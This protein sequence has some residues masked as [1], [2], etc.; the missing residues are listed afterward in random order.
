MKNLPS[1]A[2][3]KI[4]S[5]VL[6]FKSVFLTSICI[7]VIPC[8]VPATLKSISPLKSSKPIISDKI[9][10]FSPSLTK[11]MAIP[12][13]G[14]LSGTPASIKERVEP[15]TEAMEVDPLED[16]ISETSLMV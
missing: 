14:A 2:C 16:I 1:L 13:T 9:T 6:R 12:E 5:T 10:C 7:A 11:P 8:L 3:F 15:Q 4:F